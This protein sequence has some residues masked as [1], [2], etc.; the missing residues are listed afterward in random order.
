MNWG[1]IIMWVWEVVKNKV[2]GC[3]RWRAVTGDLPAV[4]VLY[5]TTGGG[6]PVCANFM[7]GIFAM[8]KMIILFCMCQMAAIHADTVPVE[9]M[10]KGRLRVAASVRTSATAVRTPAA[11]RKRKKIRRFNI[12]K[13]KMVVPKARFTIKKIRKQTLKAAEPPRQFRRYF[14]SGTDEAE[15]ESVINEEISQLFNLL[16]TSRRRDLRL[17]LGS[18]Y[19]EKA[20][21]IEYRLYEE[22]DQQLKLFDQKKRKTKPRLN[23]KPTYVYVNKAIKLFE[24]YHR[25]YPKDRRMDQVLFFLGVSYF[26]RN[27]LAKGKKRYEELVKRFPKS[28]YVSDAYF[29]L[30]EYYFS[31]SNWRKA[32]YYYTKIAGKPRL[33]LHSFA[34]YKLA[35]CRL[36]LGQARRGLK[37]LERVIRAGAKHK[38][39][40]GTSVLSSSRL[41]FAKEA[42]N[43]LALFYSRAGRTPVKALSYFYKLSGDSAKSFKMLKNLA[44]AYLDQGYLK[45]IRITFRQLVDEKP[46]APEAYEYQYQ[47]IRAYTHSGLRKIFLQELKNWLVKYGPGSS[48]EAQNKGSAEVKKA[49]TLMESTVRNYALRMH[50]SFKKTRDKTAKR[51]ALFGYEIYNQH[52][53]KSDF[54]DQMR[55]FYA[56]LLF[57][58][59]KYSAASRQYMYIVEH[60]KSSKYY[61]IASLNGVLA[62]E[63]GLPS[64]K[65]IRK[66]VGKRKSFVPFT[67]PI[68]DFHK[69]AH[70]YTTRF[71]K[72]QNVPAIL[73]K[74]ASLHYEFNHYQEA[75]DQ[76]WALIKNYP[77]SSYTEYSAN[78]ILDIYNLR[79]DFEGLRKA[80]QALL[81][82]P[83]IARSSSAPGMQ[84]ILSQISLKTAEDM[85]KQKKY[86]ESAK[87]Y[88]S[89]ADTHPRSPLRMTAYYN[90]GVNF[91]KTGD[92]LK[93]I[94]LYRKV[95]GSRKGAKKLHKSIRTELPDLYQKTGQ[96]RQAAVAF[97]DFARSYPQDSRS[98]DFWYNAALI[99]DGF[100]K[101]PQAE[102]AYLEYFKKSRKTD[103]TQALYLLAEL[104]KRWGRSQKAVSYYQQFL[105]RG[106]A[107][108][109]A[110]VSSAFKIAEIKKSQ[111]AECR[112]RQM[113]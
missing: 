75:L 19:V 99:Y 92:R 22:Y 34:L 71:P 83:M 73:Y 41:H 102:Q 109:M 20:Q 87:L 60:F 45:G 113:V 76:F 57:D 66:I 56:E 9:L 32:A 5:K 6:L 55:F 43:D 88:K 74:M 98:P 81:K 36:N 82:N 53:G 103:K 93:T 28:R 79:K 107:D 90:A 30:G 1:T 48:W 46:F 2:A 70:H 80:A 94:N 65:S 78:L 51:Q 62:L 77:K 54:K 63:K 110:L 40:Q 33:R 91:R 12:R 64:S 108:R 38:A 101:Y 100:N 106:S 4:A 18:L 37:N 59:K 21:F 17:R 105:N 35:W 89:F 27:Q 29:E 10:Q 84:K 97:A 14:K 13:K 31:K 61:A 8:K 86:F 26:K 47:I 52:F 50:Q 68:H 104:Q 95:L 16:K 72:K 111:A 3:H 42:L 49:F 39:V 69:T 96:Y 112:C 23:L 11:R 67:R 44:Y 85:A 25:Q 24:T 7:Q 58:V 15:L